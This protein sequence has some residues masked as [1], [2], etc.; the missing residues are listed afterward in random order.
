MRK[1]IKPPYMFLA[2]LC[3]SQL[4]SKL[5]LLTLQTSCLFLIENRQYKEQ[6]NVGNQ[7]FSLLLKVN[8]DS[9]FLYVNIFSSVICC[10]L[11]ENNSTCCVNHRIRTL[12]AI[13]I[14]DALMNPSIQSTKKISTNCLSILFIFFGIHSHD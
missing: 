7:I 12:S 11:D 14:L 6:L 2:V 13:A 5:T 9:P 8:P 3:Q 4:H 1:G 10:S